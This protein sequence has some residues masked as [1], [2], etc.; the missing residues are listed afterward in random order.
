MTSL[1]KS[2]TKYM[3]CS[4]CTY[5][6]LLSFGDLI[7]GGSNLGSPPLGDTSVVLKY[8]YL[9]RFQLTYNAMCLCK[10]CALVHIRKGGA[11]SKVRRG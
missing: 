7:S 1:M 2:D 3:Y 10:D 5:L 9:M 11:L 6:S 8:L 4:G